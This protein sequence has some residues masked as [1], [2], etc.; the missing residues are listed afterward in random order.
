TD[1]KVIG[2]F[3]IARN[4]TERKT[5]HADNERAAALV[6]ATLDSTDNGI[7]V[8]DETGRIVMWN[9]RL[10]EMVPGLTEDLLRT[11]SREKILEQLLHLFSDPET[12]RRSGREIAMRPDY[13]DLSCVLLADGRFMERF[14]QP[15]LIEGRV[16]GRVWSFRDVTARQRELVDAGIR[17]RE[18]E[19]E[20]GRRTQA[21]ERAIAERTASEL[22]A[23]LIADN[24]PGRVAYWSSDLRG[25]FVNRFYCE[26]F[27][28]TQEEIIGKPMIELFGE[29]R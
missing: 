4:I 17:S 15:M 6:T 28:K 11:G 1:G 19:A 8:A 14:T 3:G 29:K 9:Q 25:V 26:F 7:L 21:R 22:F 27:G 20:V 2:L 18:L 16:A 12:V 10:F 5:L 23:R 13:K 24:I